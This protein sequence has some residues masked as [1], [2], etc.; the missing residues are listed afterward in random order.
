MLENANDD[1]Y[2]YIYRYIVF[3]IMIIIMCK[4]LCH[5]YYS[6]KREKRKKT[7]DLKREDSFLFWPFLAIVY[8]FCSIP[9]IHGELELPLF[10]AYHSLIE[11]GLPNR[12]ILCKQSRRESVP[13]IFILTTPFLGLP[14]N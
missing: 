1:I 9:K 3:M 6:A 13:I 12:I 4:F 14:L 10:F 7:N 5:N 2:I 11:L 8:R